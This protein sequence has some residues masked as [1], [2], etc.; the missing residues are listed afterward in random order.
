MQ[1]T[2]CALAPKARYSASV[3]D[4]QTVGWR[5]ADQDMRL[6]SRR[7][8][9][10]VVERHVSKH[11]AQSLSQYADRVRHTS[12]RM[13]KLISRVPFKYRNIRFKRPKSEI[14]G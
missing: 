6:G 4:L 13:C 11:H 10:P 8:R 9:K 14:V 5:F 1:D 2:S 3:D 7:V 12:F